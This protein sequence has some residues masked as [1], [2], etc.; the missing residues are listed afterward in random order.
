MFVEYAVPEPGTYA[1]MIRYHWYE[2]DVAPEREELYDARAHYGP[3]EQAD[4]D[5]CEFP[6]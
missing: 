2:S 3:N 5:A 4:H 6:T 1:L